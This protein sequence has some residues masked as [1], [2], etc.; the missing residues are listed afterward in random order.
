[1]AISWQSTVRTSMKIPA[2]IGLLAIAVFAIGFGL[3]AASAPISGAAIASGI[4]AVSGQNQ[5]IDHLEGGVVKEIMVEEGKRVKA[6]DA[7][8]ALDNTIAL[9]NLTRIQG[10]LIALQGRLAR[11]KAENFGNETVEF[12]PALMKLASREDVARVINEQQIEFDTRLSRHR[13]ELATLDQREKSIGQEIQGITLQKEAENKKLGLLQEEISI[14]KS[15]L[16]KGLTSRGQYSALVREEAEIIGRIGSLT[17]TIAQ[18]WVGVAEANERR[19]AM[20]ATRH[21]TA[22]TLVNQLRTEFSDLGQQLRSYEN[23]LSRMVIR[24][25][26][27]GIILKLKKNTIGS[28]IRPGEEIV[29][30]LPLSAELVADVRVSPA[31]VDV[32]RVGQAA[33]LRFVSLNSRTTPEISATVIWVSADRLIDPATRE[34]YF[35][36]RLKMTENLPDEIKSTQIFP[37]MPVDAFI[38]T[39]ERT[40]LQYLSRP[41]FD[42]FAKAFREE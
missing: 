18:K 39:D 26:G 24:A 6:G 2:A 17:A 40:F 7:I 23:V 41:I 31:D 32:V 34:P 10:K 29:T 36:A 20:I 16:D 22:A 38:K 35:G 3:W 28:V 42:S 21:E 33:S 11:A 1:M 27:D 30:L 8:I 15:L 37:G 13:A 19:N 25:P 4:V 5:I 9:S 12:P 14:K